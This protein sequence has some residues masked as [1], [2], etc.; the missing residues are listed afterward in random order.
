MIKAASGKTILD[1][2]WTAVEETWIECRETRWE[3]R[4]F[5]GPKPAEV[6]RSGWTTERFAVSPA[7]P[8]DKP[9]R[10]EEAICGG[11]SQILPHRLDG[12]ATRF[13]SK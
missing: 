7:G 10:V 2:A 11:G 9:V 12:G 4:A 5:I 1:A 13:A 3:V 8:H 6:G